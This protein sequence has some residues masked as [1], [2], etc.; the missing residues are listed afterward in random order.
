[1]TTVDTVTHDKTRWSTPENKPIII[2]SGFIVVILAIGTAYTLVTQGTATLLSP[3][4]ML[5]QLQ[6]GSFLGI[7]A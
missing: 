7:V 2:A 1:M 4:Y 6:V 5:Q 3:T